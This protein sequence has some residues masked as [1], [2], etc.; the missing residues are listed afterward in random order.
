VP[1]QVRPSRVLLRRSV[2]R[3]AY[4]TM[5]EPLKALRGPPTDTPRRGRRYE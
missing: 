5:N 2:L 4:H 1:P 3:E